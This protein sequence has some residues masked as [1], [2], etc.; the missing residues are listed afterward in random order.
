MYTL[1]AIKNMERNYTQFTYIL[2]FQ[3]DHSQ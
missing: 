3:H 2:Q 1:I